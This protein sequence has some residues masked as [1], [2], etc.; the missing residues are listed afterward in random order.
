MYW[1]IICY[2]F[3]S[4]HVL[5]LSS[6]SAMFQDNR[7]QFTLIVLPNQEISV[8]RPWIHRMLFPVKFFDRNILQVTIFHLIKIASWLLVHFS[9]LQTLQLQTNFPSQA[10]LLPHLLSHGSFAEIQREWPFLYEYG[11]NEISTRVLQ[12][13]IWYLL[14]WFATLL[15]CFW[16]FWVCYWDKFFQQI[17]FFAFFRCSGIE[18]LCVMSISSLNIKIHR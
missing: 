6:C 18:V 11:W 2:F 14:T 8:C 13:T 4:L 10:F 9:H 5:I 1:T 16:L 7:W 17:S 15:Y 12:L 3:S